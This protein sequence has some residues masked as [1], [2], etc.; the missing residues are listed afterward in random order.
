MRMRRWSDL[1]LVLLA[2]LVATSVAADRAV[3]AGL[4]GAVTGTV[5]FK[6]KVPP[7]TPV[8]ITADRGVCG[9]K[10]P[11]YD[12]SLIVGDK[13][14][15]ANAVVWID[16]VTGGRRASAST[17]TVLDQVNCV[18]VPHVQAVVTGSTLDFRN[19]DAALHNVHSTLDG[20]TLF[21]IGL[22]AKQRAKEALDEPGVVAFKCD[23]G[24]TWMSAYIH[25]FDHPYFA[26]TGED[27]AFSI[28][29]LPA[30]TYTLHVWHEK[31]GARTTKVTVGAKPASVGI[32]YGK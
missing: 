7:S 20:D 25:V 12:E 1:G 13:G 19:S 15:L 21:N 18:Y 10:G 32:V 9:K 16:G 5:V 29:G 30:G 28:A 23:A 2:A 26:V 24:H 31:L 17:T 27:G 22:P 6:G 4:D 14:G 8:K 11:I 3:G